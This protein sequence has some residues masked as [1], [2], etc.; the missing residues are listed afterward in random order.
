MKVFF[1]NPPF[2]AQYGKFSRESRSPAIGHSGVLYYPLWLIYAAAV[3][4]KEGF[5]IE[6]LDAPAKNMDEEAS[7]NY[8]S[9]HAEDTRLFVLDT[10][11]PSIYSDIAFAGTIKDRYP[12]AFILLVGTHPSSTVTET[13]EAD[14]R[15]DGIARKEYDYIIKNLA[16]T[17]KNNVGLEKVDGLTYRR[18]GNLIHNRDA[19]YITE[20]DEIPFAAEF[21][22]KHLD[23]MDYSFPAASYPSIQ[24]F[25]GRG[26]PARCNFCVYPQTLHG[27][28]YRLRSAQNVIDEIKYI[29]ANFPR[30]KEIVIEDDTFTVN[31]KRVTEICNLL[32]EN[33]LHKRLK[34]ICNARVNLDFETMKLM[35][36]AGCHLIIPGIESLNQT[37][38][39]N[40]KKGTTVQQIEK[41]IAN[42]KKAG[43]LVHACYMVG[44]QGETKET[45]NETLKAALRFK[46]D[47]A[48]FF[49]LVPYPGTEA[50]TWAKS[51]GYINGRYDEYCNED[52]T[53]SCVINLPEISA[54]EFVDFCA[55]ARKKYYLRFWY[56]CHRLW[57]GMLNFDDLKRSLKAFAKFKTYL[58]NE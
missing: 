44:N 50:Y 18:S 43:L 57:M 14:G 39:N 20:L 2:K 9:E 21:I 10:S 58:F 37:I 33:R 31:K 16:Y 26:C 4:E 29:A 7:L 24:I 13:M 15:I 17:I 11:T 42:A 23:I 1:V 19:E 8:V 3:V 55:F 48:Q 52:G 5:D 35:K 49:P 6:F 22:K 46:T 40:I 41:Y 38:L 45:M 54:Q 56:I 25:T 47:T 32:I 51:Y 36:K 12:N 53:M 27:H 34:W 28:Q 30:V